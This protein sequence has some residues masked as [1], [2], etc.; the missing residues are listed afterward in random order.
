[1]NS[2]ERIRMALA[3]KEADRIPIDFGAMRSTGISTIAYNKLRAELGM[4]K[5]LPKMYDFIQ[6]LAYPEKEI[7]EIFHIDAIDAGQ[8][9]LTDDNDWREWILNDGSRCLIPKYLN[10]EIDNNSTVIVKDN[11]GKVLG[12]KPKS[13][14]YVDQNYWVYGD[15]PGIPDRFND[16]DLEKFI[17]AIPSPPWNLDI[18]DDVQYKYFIDTIKNLYETTDYSIMLAVGCNLF[19]TG[20]WLR[21]MDNFL[22]DIYLDKKG[23]KRLVSRLVEKNIRFLDRVL[24]GVGDYVDLLQFGDDLGAQNGPFMSPEVFED[25]FK[26]GYKKMWDFVHSNY[27]CKVFMHSCG[28]IY[29][30]FNHLIDVGLDVINP[31][32][33]TTTNM[34]PEKLKKEF[35]K[36]VTFWGGGCNTRDILPNKTP[37]EVKEDV[38]RRIDIFG[39]DGG[40]VFNQIHNIQYDIPVKN[41]IAMFEGAYE[42]GK[43]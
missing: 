39:K 22:C 9:F 16:N 30:L 32:Q 17:W 37:K 43:Y 21:K 29:E 33:T 24:K 12:I 38:K 23:V 3:H 15:D 14:F 27:D 41:I 31:V 26:P 4:K 11:N 8:A 2:R 36:H 19:E 34:E 20:T 7:R 25:I 13:S 35:G 6:Q 5:G 18:F 10:I 28:S 42:Y 1:M 40:F